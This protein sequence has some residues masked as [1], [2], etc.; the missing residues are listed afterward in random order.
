[1]ERSIVL[2][3]IRTQRATPM[4]HLAPT[5]SLPSTFQEGREWDCIQEGQIAAHKTIQLLDV[6][7]PQMREWKRY[8]I[9]IALTR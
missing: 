6:F 2:A 5:E 8:V 4:A 3:P 9:S 7:E 1:M